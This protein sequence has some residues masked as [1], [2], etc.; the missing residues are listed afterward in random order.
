MVE[1]VNEENK[2]SSIETQAD[3]IQMPKKEHA[4]SA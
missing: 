1:S 2:D 3:L 4:E